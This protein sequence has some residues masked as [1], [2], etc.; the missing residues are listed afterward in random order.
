MDIH[1]VIVTE[2]IV[3]MGRIAYLRGCSITE[4]PY[5]DGSEEH[6]L[7]YMGFMDEQGLALKRT[8]AI[9]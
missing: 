2:Q 3:A 4:H 6:L 1:G 5:Q 8:L 9:S 7:W